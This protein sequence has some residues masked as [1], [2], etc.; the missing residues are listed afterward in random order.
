MQTV[1]HIRNVV[2]AIFSHARKGNYFH[3]LNPASQ[4][5]VPG[6]SRKEAHMLSPSRNSRRCA[7]A[8]ALPGKGK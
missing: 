6:M 3:G 2:S 4:V 7:G 8:D 5:A 1:T